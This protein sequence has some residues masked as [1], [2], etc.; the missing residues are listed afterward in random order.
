MSAIRCVCPAQAGRL[1]WPTST[2]GRL[3]CSPR[4]RAAAAIPPPLLEAG[5]G[6]FAPCSHRP[7]HGSRPPHLL[8]GAQGLGLVGRCNLR[9]QEAGAGAGGR[10]GVAAPVHGDP[11]SR[12]QTGLPRPCRALAGASNC[13][14][15][16]IGRLAR[17][18]WGRAA[19]DPPRAS[20]APPDATW[21]HFWI[22]G[23]QEIGPPP[24][25]APSRLPPCLPPCRSSL[26]ACP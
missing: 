5:A 22:T 1:G 2:H 13:A 12:I 15:M 24:L 21:R 20:V 19:A 23:N 14:A 8:R 9:L 18:V 25:Y 10:M 4:S 17:E 6:W 26:P 16:S 3:R 7:R 11:G